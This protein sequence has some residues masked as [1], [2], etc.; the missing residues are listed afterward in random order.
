[1][2]R[3]HLPITSRLRAKA[4]EQRAKIIY[5]RVGK[6]VYLGRELIC[7]A[8]SEQRAEIILNALNGED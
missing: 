3:Q 5:H 7:D 4:E 1:M 6:A 2:E 8:S